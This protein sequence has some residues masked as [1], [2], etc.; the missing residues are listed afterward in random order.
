MGSQGSHEELSSSL[1]PVM[2]VV[3]MAFFG[4]AGASVRLVR[5]PPCMPQFQPCITQPICIGALHQL[6]AHALLQTACLQ[7]RPYASARVYEAGH[8]GRCMCSQNRV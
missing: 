2:P 1:K 6:A 4:L 8:D 7:Q 3:N 5:P